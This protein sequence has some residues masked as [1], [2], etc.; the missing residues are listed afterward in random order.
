[1]KTTYTIYL[2]A[3]PLECVSGVEYAYAVYAKT[4][5]LAELLGK[6]ACLVWDAT[7]EI[8]ADHEA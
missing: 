8:V 7:G 3:T 6:G 4:V 2:G 5:E 1:M